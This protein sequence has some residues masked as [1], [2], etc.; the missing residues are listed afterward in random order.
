MGC[1]V[2]EDIIK[3]DGYSFDLIWTSLLKKVDDDT[4][5]ILMK[6]KNEGFLYEGHLKH[7]TRFLKR[8]RKLE[9]Q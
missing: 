4:D 2:K 9:G 3:L 1:W 6:E 5:W 8:Y 7:D